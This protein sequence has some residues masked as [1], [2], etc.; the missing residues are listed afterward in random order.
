MAILEQEFYDKVIEM[1]KKAVVEYKNNNFDT[2]ED[3]AEKGW[4]LFPEPKY[5][6]NQAYNYAK[7]AFKNNFAQKRFEQSE[8]WLNR[9]IE[10]NNI[11]HSDDGEIEFKIGMYKFETE[12]LEDAYKMFREAVRQSGNNHYRYFADED[13][14]YFEFYKN[15]KKLEDEK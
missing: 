9:M 1:G 2:W 6:W 13:K 14:K 12:A 5:N 10:D 7:M 8:K 15:Q 11:N 4:K 3:Y